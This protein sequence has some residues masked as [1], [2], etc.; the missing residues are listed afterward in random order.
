LRSVLPAILIFFATPLAIILTYIWLIGFDV[1]L[2]LAMI[3]LFQLYLIAIQTEISLRQTTILTAEYDPVFVLER[4]PI[5][6]A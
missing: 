3:L 1:N 5:S 4:S 2:V 6:T